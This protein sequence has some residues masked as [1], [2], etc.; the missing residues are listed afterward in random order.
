MSVYPM[1]HAPP[2][3]PTPLRR[4]EMVKGQSVQQD[5]QLMTQVIA[6]AAEPGPTASVDTTQNY[7]N[8]SSHIDVHT[9]SGQVFN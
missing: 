6:A 5:V 7:R 3:P 2:S 1:Y 9:Q 4:D 8:L